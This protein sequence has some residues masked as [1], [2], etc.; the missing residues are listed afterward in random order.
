MCA[1][2]VL[3]W[4]LAAAN[5]HI[6]PD[7]DPVQPVVHI[8]LD[9]PIES[10]LSRLTNYRFPPLGNARSQLDVE[11]T[12]WSSH[13]DQEVARSR[14][15]L[16]LVTPSGSAGEIHPGPAQYLGRVG[17]GEGQLSLV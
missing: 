10:G 3:N 2:L 4:V 5:R 16:V 6:K 13:P 12:Y 7:G 15:D 8:C 17:A 1:P 11:L 9:V 14:G